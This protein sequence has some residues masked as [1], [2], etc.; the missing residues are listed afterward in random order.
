M[1]DNQLHTKAEVVRMQKVNTCLKGIIGRRG[2]S[3]HGLWREKEEES[4]LQNLG[5]EYLE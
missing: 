1:T 5:T 2:R 4:T 3:G